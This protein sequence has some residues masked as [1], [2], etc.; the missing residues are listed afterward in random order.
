MTKATRKKTSYIYTLSDPRDG[1]VRYVGAT[2]NPAKRYFRS[3][4]PR[5]Y[6][7]RRLGKWFG[8][9]N[10]AGLSPIMTIIETCPTV[11]RGYREVYWI[12]YYVERGAKLLNTDGVRR[13]Y[14]HNKAGNRV[15]LL[16]ES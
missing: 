9:L 12:A 15:D 2:V 5:L 3:S 16:P 13:K 7:G 6:F 11:S 4:R 1:E 10:A 14:S 8:E